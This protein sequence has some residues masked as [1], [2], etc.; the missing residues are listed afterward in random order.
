MFVIFSD[1]SITNTSLD[2]VTDFNKEQFPE[3]MTSD[4]DCSY[5]M[6]RFSVF[7]A[8]IKGEGAKGVLPLA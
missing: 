5:S 7:Q 4:N 2:D 3:T 6:K 8:C 1:F